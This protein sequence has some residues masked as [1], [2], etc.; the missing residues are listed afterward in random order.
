MW[1][2]DC[3][4]SRMWIGR[5]GTWYASGNPAG[6]TNYAF[7]NMNVHTG[8]TYFKLAYHTSSS[9]SAKYEIKT[10]AN[11]TVIGAFGN[12]A[13]T[14]FNP[15]TDDT[16]AIRGQETGYAT[17]NPLAQPISRSSYSGGVMSNGNL[18]L[19]G[20]STVEARSFSTIPIPQLENIILKLVQDKQVMTV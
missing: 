13:A 16:N 1:A 11:S 3:G 20:G 19:S 10:Q 5:N 4:S 15:F 6:G 7:H 18:T 2:V 12:A 17:L 9:T 14:N 8:G